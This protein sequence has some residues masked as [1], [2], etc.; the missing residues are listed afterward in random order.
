MNQIYSCSLTEKW[1]EAIGLFTFLQP[2]FHFLLISLSVSFPNTH[3]SYSWLRG[4]PK[5]NLDPLLKKGWR[6]QISLPLS[7]FLTSFQ[8]VT[9]I[10]W[11]LICLFHYS[12]KLDNEYSW[13]LN[14]RW[15]SDFLTNLFPFLDS[16][17][18]SFSV[19]LK[20]PPSFP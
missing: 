14:N 13:S 10:I 15:V 19:F 5:N 2:F 18:L 4:G 9:I 16:L 1:V 11:T 7:I 12:L 6:S 20:T 17:S 3:L 8:S